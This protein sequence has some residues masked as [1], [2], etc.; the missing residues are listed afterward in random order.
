MARTVL[1]AHQ[2]RSRKSLERLLQ[3]A[4]EILEKDGLEGATIPRIAAR[5]GLTPGAVYRRFPDKDA[6]L[7]EL[8]MRLFQRNHERSQEF[9]KPEL[10]EGVSLPE[11]SRRVITST[12]KAYRANRGLLRALFLFV[13]QH[14][15]AA[16]FRKGQEMQIR[17]FHQIGDLLLTRKDEIRHPDPEFAVRFGMIM[18]SYVIQS[19]FLL[20]T[21]PKKLSKLVPGVEENMEEEVPKMF[22]RYLGV[23]DKGLRRF[24]NN[25]H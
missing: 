18:V 13:M 4:Q 14:Q 25:L 7:R 22:L 20:P 1:P 21:D 8:C 16:F 24:P 10:W 12:I 19:V 15:D 17:T 11:M 23:E 2:A 9:L 3:A 6:L 5:A